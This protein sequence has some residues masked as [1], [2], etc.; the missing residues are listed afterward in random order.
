MPLDFGSTCPDID[1]TISNLKDII[2]S[3]F[4]D[5]CS[6]ISTYLDSDKQQSLADDYT[7]ALAN[8]ILDSFEQVRTTN[9][10]MR[11]AANSQIGN[12]EDTIVDLSAE[13]EDLK[14]Y[15]TTLEIE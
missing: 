5:I 3:A 14:N 7:E 8:D 4:Y 13:L 6:D 9:E 10:E 1:R 12:L 15:V 11:D 2:A